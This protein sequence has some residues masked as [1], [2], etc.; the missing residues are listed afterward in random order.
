MAVAEQLKN[1][2]KSEF[3]RWCASQI[4]TVESPAGSNRV[5][6]WLNTKPEWNGNAWCAAFLQSGALRGGEDMRDDFGWG[7]YYVPQITA[8]AK[9]A[10]Q[11][12]QTPRAGDWIVMGNSGYSHI[13]VVEKVIQGAV[14]G[15]TSLIVQTIEG[16][17]S[18]TSAG[19]QNNGGGVYRKRRTGSFVKGFIRIKYAPEAP[20]APKPPSP[21]T[22]DKVKAFQK[23]LEL[24]QDGKWGPDT[25]GRALAFRDVANKD[26][27][28]TASQIRTVQ[29]IVDTTVDGSY[30]PKTKAAVV[31]VTKQIQKILGVTQ[32]G[33]WG[34]NTDRKFLEFRKAR[35]LS[36]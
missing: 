27:G 2:T 12:T 8:D 32:D 35:K 24:T 36:W 31:A 28:Q 7:P 3:L 9:A 15:S 21:W 16:N 14:A 6:Y 5:K 25:D 33:S 22:V 23:I 4:G 18:P 26:R 20:S 17:T 13:G 11:W 19:S 1:L 29:R 10:G 30:G 34:P